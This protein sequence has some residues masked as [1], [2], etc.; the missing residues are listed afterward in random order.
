MEKLNMC[1]FACRVDYDAAIRK[2]C[3]EADAMLQNKSSNVL[4]GI[5]EER[6][7]RTSL[8]QGAT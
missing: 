2:R 6:T 5:K 7:I 8:E 4:T 1:M 3:E